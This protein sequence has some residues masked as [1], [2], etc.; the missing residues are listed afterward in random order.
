ML[1]RRILFLIFAGLALFVAP[2]FARA[3]STA[4]SVNTA[5]REEVRQFY[6]A[7]YSASENIPIGWTGDYTAG[8]A[9]DTSAAFKEATR[10]RINFF[11]ALVG[12]P[13]DV[14]LNPTYNA[15]AQQAALLQ[16]VNAAAGDLIV[17]NH[18]PP[19]SWSFFT[20]AAAEASSKSNLSYGSVGPA[21]ITSYVVDSGPTNAPVGHRRW[22]FYPQTLQMGV[23]D[24][25]GD[26]T[27]G[28][29][30]ANA[31]WIIDG[32]AGGRFG[33]PRPATRT[34]HIP[35]PPAGFV[36]YSLVF[37]RWS[38]SHPNADFTATTVRMTRNGQPIAATLEPLL[39]V[40]IGEPTLVWVYDDKNPDD[41]S[42]HARPAADTVYEVTLANVRI[43]AAVRDFS[44][45]VTVFDPDVVGPDFSPVTI[46]GPASI[47]LGTATTF[48][49]AKPTYATAFDWRALQFTD[50]SK[51]YTAEPGLSSSNGPGLSLSNGSDSGLRA[52]DALDG[53][54]ATTSPG[55]DVVQSIAVGSG[56]AAFQ[57]AHS[58]DR[59]DQIL[60]LPDTYLVASD[61]A[62]TF[63]SRLGIATAT[64]TA[65]VQLSTDGGNSWFD[66]YRQSGTSPTGSAAPAPT[67]PAFITRSLS[68]A[69]YAGRT[70]EVRFVLSMLAGGAGYLPDAAN[71]IGWFLDNLTISNAQ[72]ASTASAPLRIGAGTTFSFAPSVTGEIALQARGLI[73]GAYPLEW[74]PVLPTNA[75]PASSTSSSYLTNL[76]VRTSAGAGD[77][78][79]IVGFRIEGGTKQILLRGIG[80]T[81][82]GFGIRGVL[83]DPRLE[84]FASLGR[85]T[86]NDNWNATSRSSF[87]AVGAFDL[88]PGSR[89]AVLLQHV[90]PDN[91]TVQ[92]SG[93]A[94]STGVALVEL[95]DTRAG[96][97]AARL[98]NVSAR[99]PVGTGENVLVAGFTVGGSGSRQLLIRAVGPT[100]TALGVSGALLD[101]KLELFNQSSVKIA[102]ND[103]WS[104]ALA[105]S[106]TRVGAFQLTPNSRDAVLIVTLPPGSY[107]AQVSGVSNTTGVALVEVYE[108]P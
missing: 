89:D 22:L 13:A 9:G 16:S 82:A 103:N 29:G 43:G 36:P 62:V 65:R 5:S 71:P 79:L 99:S 40:S 98:A 72:I 57:L 52:S 76:S 67:E 17:L 80:P 102:E 23:G 81:L 38:F 68:L 61:S 86:E 14:T 85:V 26:G 15:Q 92:L 64:Q 50:A 95:Y 48:S 8:Q 63:Q 33:D 4:L 78:T 32:A 59:T 1:A 90:S 91:Y 45:R 30:P 49:I 97:T 70:V 106:F 77:N 53:L 96:D 18:T 24:V 55:Y 3:Q 104:A 69:P 60:A 47:P 35:Y 19:A 84:L 83:A 7:V 107:T 58:P 41:D 54:R 44:Y 6:R 27:R 28:R 10:L 108:L 21:A 94:G 2:P 42:P 39:P 31:T 105:S 11:R 51:T 46:T 37:P 66:I 12:I 87:S 56:R 20:A 25:P 75:V 101:P 100:L 74:G 34:E 93:N 88:A 73:A